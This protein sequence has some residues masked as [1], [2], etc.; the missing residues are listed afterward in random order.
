MIKHTVPAETAIP[1]QGSKKV[2]GAK[3]REMIRYSRKESRIATG[4]P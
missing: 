2:C 3:P 1:L 4:I